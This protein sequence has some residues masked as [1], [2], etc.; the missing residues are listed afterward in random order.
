MFDDVMGDL[1]FSDPT[2]TSATAGV[3]VTAFGGLLPSYRKERDNTGKDWKDPTFQTKLNGHARNLSK[4]DIQALWGQY[5]D[6]TTRMSKVFS[7]IL[8]PKPGVW[9]KDMDYISQEWQEAQEEFVLKPG[10]VAEIGGETYDRIDLTS[11]LQD[12]GSL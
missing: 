8:D 7:V 3:S 9:A 10:M 2:I 4:G 5:G 6:I 12:G 1:R 11:L